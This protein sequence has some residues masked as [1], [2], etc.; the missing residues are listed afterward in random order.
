V[1]PITLRGVP[2]AVERVIRRRASEKGTSLNRAAIELLE[3]GTGIGPR[4]TGAR[5]H[6]LDELAGAW[7]AEEAKAFEKALD[8]QRAIDEEVWR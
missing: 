5:Y 1:K 8:A 4:K 3:R 7:S 2:P 6:D